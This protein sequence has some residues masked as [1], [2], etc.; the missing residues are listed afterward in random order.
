MEGDIMIVVC[1]GSGTV[2]ILSSLVQLS[3]YLLALQG[4]CGHGRGVSDSG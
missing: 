3:E 2:Q 1:L 4:A